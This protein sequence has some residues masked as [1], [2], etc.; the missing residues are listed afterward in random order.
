[1]QHNIH[2]ITRGK[3]PFT[4]KDAGISKGAL[5]GVATAAVGVGRLGFNADD[6]MVVL[7][8]A[9]EGKPIISF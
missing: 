5:D 1:M 9:F 3:I 2:D 7:E 6:C 4:L 8:H